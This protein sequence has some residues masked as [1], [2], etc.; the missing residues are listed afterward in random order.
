[1]STAGG[2]ASRRTLIAVEL[3]LAL[4]ALGGAVYAFGGAEGARRE[5]LDGTPFNDYVIPGLILLVVVGGSLAAAAVALL[6]R[7]PVAWELSAA[8]GAVVLAWIVVEALMIGLVS[9]MQPA[10]LAVGMLIV[11]LAIRL[12][13]A[14]E[15][16]P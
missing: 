4:N 9:W 2:A 5:W 14:G 16:E 13:P 10:T 3:I 8:A 12:R 7:A 6:R 15:G 11:G 1:M